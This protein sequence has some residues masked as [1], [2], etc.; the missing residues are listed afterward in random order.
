M[1]LFKAIL[2]LSTTYLISSCAE[3]PGEAGQCRLNCGKAIIGPFEAE[4]EAVGEER[5]ILC[6]T[7]SAGQA[8]SDPLLFQFVFKDKFKS[9]GGTDQNTP[10]PNISFDPVVTGARS[11]LPEH[12]PN[13]TIENGVFTP[14]R[15]R[16]IV[17]E[18]RNWC[19]DTC[20]VAT[21][22]IVAVCPP[23]GASGEISVQLHSGALFSDSL[24]VTVATE[25]DDT[26]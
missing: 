23:A 19:S 14:A 21:V 26:L 2:L 11:S 7:A 6:P 13:V 9:V 1:K 24:K 25:E 3:E 15:Y 12:N 17:T 10:L 18:S 16:G 20:G 8:I 22:E 4:I 5:E